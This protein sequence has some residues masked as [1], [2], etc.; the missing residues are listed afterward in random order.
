M[1]SGKGWG[2][3]HIGKWGVRD[4]ERRG[5]RYWERRDGVGS[6]EGWDGIGLG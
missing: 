5:G 6:W 2:E 3:E 4:W 1:A